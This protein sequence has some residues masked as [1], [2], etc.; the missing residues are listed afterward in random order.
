[1]PGGSILIT[2]D[3]TETVDI[4]QFVTITLDKEGTLNTDVVG[5]SDRANVGDKIGRASCRERV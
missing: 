3:D 4:P 5:G 2:D 1:M